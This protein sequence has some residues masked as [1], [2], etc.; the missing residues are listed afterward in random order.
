MF[1]EVNVLPLFPTPLFARLLDEAH[2]AQVTEALAPLMNA[3][4]ERSLRSR[5]DL[6][7]NAAFKPLC[8]WTEAMAADAMRNLKAETTELDVVVL[9]AHRLTP[10]GNL[11]LSVHPNAYFT[12]LCLLQGPDGQLHFYD[13]RPQALQLA[14]PQQAKSALARAQAITRLPR[15]RM[16]LFPSWLM[17]S[18]Q[19]AAGEPSLILVGTLLFRDFATA[20]SPPAGRGPAAAVQDR[21]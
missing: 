16:L 14:P 6:D 3:E 11:P 18:L 4:H 1:A 8:R 9:Q 17:H 2:L 12:A 13:P 19:V 15:G 21:D 20:I 7:Q 5:P 10:G